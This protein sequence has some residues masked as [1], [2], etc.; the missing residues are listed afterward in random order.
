MRRGK[1]LTDKGCG[2][3]PRGNAG[4][5]SSLDFLERRWKPAV[6]GLVCRL[7]AP[8]WGVGCQKRVPLPE[9]DFVVAAGPSQS[10]VVVAGP[11]TG[12]TYRL[13][14]RVPP[15]AGIPRQNIVVLTLTNETVKH[16]R[17]DMPE[18]AAMTV[19]SYA[20][21]KLN[22]LGVA[23][24]KRIADRW[25]QAQ[26]VR[27]DMKLLTG[28]AGHRVT[29]KTVDKFLTKLGAGFRDTMT[30]RPALTGTEAA[31]QLAWQ[32]VRD[33]LS[34]RLLDELAFDLRSALDAGH[35][36]AHP[37]PTRSW[38]TNGISGLDARELLSTIRTISERT[39]AGVF[40]ASDDRQSIYGF[41]EADPLGLNSFASVYGTPGPVFMSQSRRCPGRVVRLAEA[42]AAAMPVVP[43][44]T[45]RPALTSTDPRGG[46]VRVL[47]CR[48]PTAECSWIVRDIDRRLR[49]SP[50]SE[51][52]MIVPRDIKFYIR[53]LQ[54]QAGTAG[55]DIRFIDPIGHPAIAE[56][57][58]VRLA[59]ALLR[60]AK[61]PE[62]GL[63]LACCTPLNL[64]R[65][66]IE[67]QGAVRQRKR[68]AQPRAAGT[69]RR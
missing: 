2:A 16:L 57:E 8:R 12:K 29:V 58:G 3:S 67:G 42:V 46:E 22:A 19:H 66:R 4:I 20:L 9:I 33:F 21:G 41:R 47:S 63:R 17:A 36:P 48:S 62:D 59:Y 60:L 53:E 10:A 30:G 43:G 15:L 68:P 31:L 44:L 45:G 28:A 65:G 54:D 51:I 1:Y 14:E 34:M 64:G 7:T 11:G 40:A 50:A 52:A 39:G 35:D 61:D 27:V 6:G 5:E 38:W 37:T 24:T 18:P 32:R 13:Q 26:L 55:I 56:D 23:A 49:R 25:E 69:R